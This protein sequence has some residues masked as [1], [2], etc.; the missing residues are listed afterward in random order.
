MLVICQKSTQ[1]I[2][3]IADQGVILKILGYFLTAPMTWE[4][5]FTSEGKY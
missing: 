2:P 4:L 5:L 1:E 3:C